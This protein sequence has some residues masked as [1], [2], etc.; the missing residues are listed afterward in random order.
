MRLFHW[1]GLTILIVLNSCSNEPNILK[2][3]DGNTYQII[4]HEDLLW[5]AENLRVTKDPAGSMVSY[6]IPGSDSS[7][8]PTYGLLYDYEI[9]CKVCPSGWRLPTN[10]EWESFLDFKNTNNAGAFKNQLWEGETNT[11]TSGFSVSPTGI[12]NHQEH[13][14]Q[15]GENSLYWSSDR[16]GEHFIWTYIFERGSNQ[17]RKASQHPTY[18]FSVRCVKDAS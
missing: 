17:I 5:M 14:N 13:P 15:F 4:Q 12:G 9:A 1:L 11:N 7:T 6:Y 16:D 18:A 8:I 3:N 10:D 2:D